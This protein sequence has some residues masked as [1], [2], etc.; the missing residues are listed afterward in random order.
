MDESMR[1]ILRYKIVRMRF[2]W[3]VRS[4]MNATTKIPF[5]IGACW[6]VQHGQTSLLNH[7]AFNNLWQAGL[8]SSKIRV[9]FVI[10]SSKPWIFEVA[11]IISWF[12]KWILIS[13]NRLTRWSQW[14][15]EFSGSMS[16]TTNFLRV[17]PTWQIDQSTARWWVAWS[18]W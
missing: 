11:L 18:L 15:N 17:V 2:T 1:P 6:L 12:S 10:W 8:H 4:M 3:P 9:R 5:S 13:H 7:V 14:V 16:K